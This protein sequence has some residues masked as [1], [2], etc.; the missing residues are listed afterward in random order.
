MADEDLTTTLTGAPWTVEP[1]AIVFIDEPTVG[2]TTDE[3]YA[4]LTRDN[5]SVLVGGEV[6]EPSIVVA[7]GTDEEH[8]GAMVALVPTDA[9][10]QR[11]ALDGYESPDQ[12]HLTLVYLGEGADWN[13]EQR[14]LLID[15]LTAWDLPGPI[16]ANAFGVSNL[17]PDGT[18][19][20]WVLNVG[21]DEL[22][23]VHELVEEVLEGM[24][25]EL[26]VIPDQ[27]NPWL[28][29]ITLAYTE[30][31][32]HAEAARSLGP[33]TFDR[34]RLAFA[35][36]VTD[37]PLDNF[38]ASLETSF[39]L[40]GQHNQ[41]THG[42]GGASPSEF[43]TAD[44]LNRGKKLDMSNPEHARLHGTINAWSGGGQETARVNEEMH[45]A[46]HDPGADTDG[47]HLM[48]V[49]AAAP[50]NAPELHRGMVGT[51]PQGSLPQEGDVF[52][53]GPT[54]FSKSK[55]V[56]A[57]F[58]TPETHHYGDSVQMHLAKGSHSLSI[59]QEVTGKFSNEQEHLSM[60]RFKVTSRTDRTV[61][62]T[63]KNGVKTQVT[64]TEL[65]MTQVDESVP[66]THT[67]GGKSTPLPPG[68]EFL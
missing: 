37:I 2:F 58:S 50:A 13:D 5:P 29:H 31:D 16:D 63:A 25:G 44:R 53:L 10:T 6:E 35:G 14:Q 8:T 20:C 57:D 21:G 11:L 43:E 7:A 27:H 54:S 23:G 48:R 51:F 55:K 42:R 59:G 67:A 9:D 22:D 38:L 45:A 47:A 68:G 64:L 46:V 60:G 3:A 52:A 26:P 40:P 41:H 19:P 30:E 32:L 12:L 15:V 4:F 24:N 66:I 28:A 17:N 62:L 49:A 34:L 1:G 18:D 56:A 39:H 61:T 33:V 36:D 65:S